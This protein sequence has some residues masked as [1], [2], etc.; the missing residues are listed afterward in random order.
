MHLALYITPSGKTNV[1]VKTMR[2]EATRQARLQ[3]MK[4]ARIM[5]K[6]SHPNVI[7]ILGVAVYENPLMIVMELCPGKRCGRFHL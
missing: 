2:E 6:F 5:R 7:R 3:F 1:A 4:E